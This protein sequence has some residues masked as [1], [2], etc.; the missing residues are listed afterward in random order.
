MVGSTREAEGRVDADGARARQA[1]GGRAD[2][3]DERELDARL[4]C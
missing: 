4:G 3:E 2:A 1:D